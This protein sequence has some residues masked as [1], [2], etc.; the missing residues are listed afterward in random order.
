MRAIDPSHTY[1][2]WLDSVLRIMRT[3]I[4]MVS[5]NTLQT[6]FAGGYS[7]S[8]AA[9]TYSVIHRASRL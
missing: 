8:D 2:V 5:E 6:L 1:R 4:W 3:R 7:P 9:S